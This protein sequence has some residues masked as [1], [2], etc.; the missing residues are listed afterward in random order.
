[1]N[2]AP[3]SKKSWAR[4][5]E[6]YLTGALTEYTRYRYSLLMESEDIYSEYPD[7]IR[8]IKDLLDPAITRVYRSFDR[9]EAFRE[10]L[11]D[12]TW[13]QLLITQTRN[14]YVS[15]VGRDHIRTFLKKSHGAFDI[16]ALTATLI[17]EYLP[18]FG[19]ILNE[20][21]RI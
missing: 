20:D 5:A 15:M 3:V 9:R 13:N 12:I 18:E 6:V 2:K 16:R 10:V 1:M 21:D 14:Q 11:L 19:D 4:R 17:A 7:Y 8:R